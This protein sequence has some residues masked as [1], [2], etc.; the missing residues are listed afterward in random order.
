MQKISTFTFYDDDDWYWDKHYDEPIEFNMR[1]EL[2]KVFVRDKTMRKDILKTI[3]MENYLL[4]DYIADIV[5][6]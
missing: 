6:V 3:C 1:P 4:M 2:P 5:T